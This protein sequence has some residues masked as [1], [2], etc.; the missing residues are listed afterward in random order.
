MGIISKVKADLIGQCGRALAAGK[1]MPARLG[2]PPTCSAKANSPCSLRSRSAALMVSSPKSHGGSLKATIT[3]LFSYSED[4]T[5][6]KRTF[7]NSSDRLSSIVLSGPGSIAVM[8]ASSATTRWEHLFCVSRMFLSRT[9]LC[10]T[11][12]YSEVVTVPAFGILSVAKLVHS[13]QDL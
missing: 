10:Q 11:W 8:I 4:R 12:L 6:R 9:Q 1:K 13:V 3:T 7:K 5:I 2:R